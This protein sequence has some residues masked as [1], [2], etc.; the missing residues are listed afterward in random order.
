VPKFKPH[1]PDFWEL[2]NKRKKQPMHVRHDS[3]LEYMNL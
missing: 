1:K 2:V 3:W